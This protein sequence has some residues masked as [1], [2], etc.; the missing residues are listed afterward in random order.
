MVPMS[1]PYLL[2]HHRNVFVFQYGTIN[3]PQSSKAHIILYVSYQ[4]Y[5]YA[6]QVIGRY[7]VY[8][9]SAI[10]IPKYTL[11]SNRISKLSPHKLYRFEY[12]RF[13]IKLSYFSINA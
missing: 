13:N 5:S 1:I 2:A 4:L 3:T 9:I 8:I 11:Y 6:V 10:P 12:N 7:Y